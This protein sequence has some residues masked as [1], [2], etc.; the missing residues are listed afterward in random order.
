MIPVELLRY[1][2]DSTLTVD[3]YEKLDSTLVLK[4]E[5]EIGP[6]LGTLTFRGVS[7]M[8]LPTWMPGEAIRAYYV[9]DVSS[10]FWG[11]IPVS[12]DWLESDEI[13]VEIE[14]QDGPVCVVVAKELIYTVD[15]E[16]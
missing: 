3:S 15:S 6:E 12:R 10:E 16:S 11:R 9:D 7:F 5:K 14:T 8:A 4:V 2:H 13:V 1:F